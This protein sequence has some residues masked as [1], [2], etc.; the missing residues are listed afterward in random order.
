MEPPRP[1]ATPVVAAPAEPAP[2]PEPELP[3]AP[4]PD[5]PPE[6]APEPA[7]EPPTAAPTRAAPPVETPHADAPVRNAHHRPKFEQ[8]EQSFTVRVYNEAENLDV[9]FSCEPGEYVLEAADRAGFELP[10]SC[11]SGG[12]L[13]C[14]G[15]TKTGT[16]ELGEQYVL[17]DDHLAKGFTLL[18]IATPT[19]DCVFESH[20]QDN[21]E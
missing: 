17:D 7:P 11:R 18:C 13:T 19:S 20:Q 1:A 14:S 10:Y 16:F 3:P 15:H 8:T 6:P 9:T 12:C 21:I 5:L 2:V 4:A